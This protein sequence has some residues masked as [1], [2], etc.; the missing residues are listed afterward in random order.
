MSLI[1]IQYQRVHLTPWLNFLDS[2]KSSSHLCMCVSSCMYVYTHIYMSFI[3]SHMCFICSCLYIIHRYIY[4]YIYVYN[5]I[6]EIYNI[7][8]HN[9]PKLLNLLAW[10]SYSFII[11]LILIDLYWYHLSFP[12]SVTSSHLHS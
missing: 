10:Y 5:Y 7:P 11:Y 6:A 3:S 2:E 1:L 9:L 4:L 12:K 8:N